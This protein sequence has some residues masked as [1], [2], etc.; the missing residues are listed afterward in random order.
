[1][2][3]RMAR[4]GA[5]VTVVS[6]HFAIPYV[7]SGELVPV[8]PEWSLPDVTA[9]AVF[10]GRRLMPARTRVL[11]DAMAHTFS[12]PE[13]RRADDE[14]RQEVARGRRAATAA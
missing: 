1:M 11:L 5:G 4:A 8:L 6:S 3:I 9:W 2:L 13:C 10:P 14:V 7:R 12:G